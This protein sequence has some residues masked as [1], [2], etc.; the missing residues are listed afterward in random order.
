WVPAGSFRKSATESNWI[1][2]TVGCADGA[3][4]RSATIETTSAA[5]I[6]DPPRSF[7]Q[8]QRDVLGIALGAP[9][10]DDDELFPLEHVGDRRGGR[11]GGQRGF[12]E[13][14][15]GLLVEGAEL[16]AAGARRDRVRHTGPD[17]AAAAHHH[18]IAFTREQQRPGHEQPAAAGIAER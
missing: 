10:R 6:R 12:P 4:A 8:T 16:V 15:A 17:A 7:R 5:F 3:A 9:D 13:D 2:G 14:R 11:A 18:R 1:S